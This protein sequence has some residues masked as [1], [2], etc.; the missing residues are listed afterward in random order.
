MASRFS[1][2]SGNAASLSVA[3][4]LTYRLHDR[5]PGIASALGW[6]YS[7]ELSSENEGPQMQIS[8][9]AATKTATEVESGLQV[10]FVRVDGPW[11]EPN[12]L[13]KAAYAGKIFPFAAFSSSHKSK[14]VEEQFRNDAGGRFLEYSRRK[15]IEYRVD[16]YES[17]DFRHF[18]LEEPR[19]SFALFFSTW[20]A[21]CE[22]IHQSKVVLAKMPHIDGQTLEVVR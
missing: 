22:G 13:F 12:T 14:E 16:Y 8:Y 21:T 11:Q 17:T 5:D 10:S 6:W 1:D 15:E 20:I 18:F 4:P 3:Q 9:D 19:V 7:S 2:R